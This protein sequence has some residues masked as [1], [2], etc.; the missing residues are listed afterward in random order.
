MTLTFYIN[1][2]PRYKVRKISFIGNKV[3]RRERAAG[4]PET[5]AGDFFDQHQDERR[6][7]LRQRP[8]RQQRLRICRRRRPICSSTLEPGELD[9]VYQVTEGKQC[10]RRRHQRA[11]RR[12]QPAHAHV[13]GAQPAVAAAGRH[14]RHS[15][16]SA[17]ASDGSRARACSTSIRAR[18]TYPRS[19]SRRPTRTRARWPRQRRRASPARTGNPDSFRGQSPDAEPQV[20]TP[21]RPDNRFASGRAV[22]PPRP[23]R[24]PWV[25]SRRARG[26][27]VRQPKPA[28]RPTARVQSPD[29]GYGGYGGQAVNPISPGPKPYTVNQAPAGYSTQ[30]PIVGAPPAGSIYTGTP[31]ANGGYAQPGYAPPGYAPADARQ[32]RS[33]L[34]AIRCLARRPNCWLRRDDRP[35]I[36][37]DI[38]LNEA[39][40]GRFMFG[41]GV[42]SNAGLVGSIV[43][44][45]QNFDWR[46]VAHQL[47]RLPQRP[48]IP[49][50]RP[51]VSHRGGARHASLAVH[52]QLRRALPVRHAG[53]LRSERLLLQAVLSRLERTTRRRSHQPGLSVLARP[54]RQPGVAG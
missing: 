32:D 47:G 26:R 52:V 49:R 38:Y 6:H 22:P 13:D 16:D 12:R 18:A 46:R 42:N 50:R 30:P 23:S 31:A 8:V 37:L 17:P 51:E 11:H 27:P 40:T 48:R 53:E 35:R 54:V 2:G 1:E 36:P 7:R 15:Q 4:R 44:D 45:E 41:A 21:R 39:Q 3:Y 43:I 10:L 5:E 29:G 33:C 34:A 9:L 20:S 28:S 14:H 19:C 24:N 25:R